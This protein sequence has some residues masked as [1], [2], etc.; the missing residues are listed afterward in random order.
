MGGA[1]RLT[2]NLAGLLTLSAT[3]RHDHPAVTSRGDVISY[4]GLAL[5]AGSLAREAR[6]AGLG[7]GDRAAILLDRGAAAAAAILG[8]HAAG[9]VA[10]ILNER[11]RGRQIE[12]ILSDSGA[13]LLVSSDEM[14]ARVGR[15][16]AAGPR[17]LDAETAGADAP[18]EPVDVASA[19]PAQI[20]YTSGSTGLPKGVVF[21]HGAIRSGVGTVSS[22]LGLR[23]D[24]RIAGLLPLGSVY[25]LNQLLCCIA[26]GGTLVVERSAFATDIVATL[27]REGVTVLAGVPP[28]WLQLL[29]VPAFSSRIAS[30]RQLQNAGGHL[31]I[32]TGRRL[33]AAQPDADIVL[34][35]GMTETWRS[36]F[37]TPDQFDARPGSMGRPVPGAEIFVVGEDRQPCAADETGELVHAGPTIAEGYW[38]QP[39]AT[40]EVFRPHPLRPGQRAVFSGDLV[41]RDA[42]GYFY[43]VGRRDRMIKTLGYRVGPD[44][45]AD[46]LHASGEVS[47]A[48]VTGEDDPE[49]GQRIVA[50]VVLTAEG[51]VERLTK[52][53]RRELPPYMQP[54]RIEARERIPRLPS[55]KF[56]FRALGEDPAV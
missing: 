56:D 35:Y 46:V 43:F 34:Q 29:A 5:R 22:Y 48:V 14:L 20:I 47:E 18:L 54:S 40:A 41:R 33:R 37:L 12:H 26:V 4:A 49:R 23:A 32:T 7:R 15:L 10:V 39:D 36:T 45:I 1:N 6:A 8:V 44:E 25:G 31:P 21:T 27:D 13:R 17:L 3:S 51:S 50:Y 38:R 11:L 55:G 19:D 53:C 42:E 2:A 30:L 9:G 28:L 16:P 52:H 24:D